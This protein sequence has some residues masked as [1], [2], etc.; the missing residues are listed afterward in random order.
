MS[1][2]NLDP[3][4]DP[5]DFIMDEDENR[6]YGDD[7]D[8]KHAGDFGY[9]ELASMLEPEFLEGLPSLINIRRRHPK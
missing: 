6:N 5:F 7:F 4:F 9:R 8:Y 3:E 1:D 2:M